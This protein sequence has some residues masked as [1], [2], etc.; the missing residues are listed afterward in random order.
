MYTKDIQSDLE[1]T[2]GV[3]AFLYFTVARWEYEF[4]L[5]RTSTEDGHRG[6]PLSTS[7][8]GENIKKCMISC[9]PIEE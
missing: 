2:L 3:S 9:W 1:E 5:R 4:K 7:F 6:G 8:T